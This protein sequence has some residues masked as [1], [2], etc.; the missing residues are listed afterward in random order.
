MLAKSPLTGLD[1][2][3]C[4]WAADVSWLVARYANELNINIETLIDNNVILISRYKCKESGFRFY[5]PSNIVGDS[6]FY[7]SL[8]QFDWYYMRSKWE[9]EEAITHINGQAVLE[10]GSGRGDFLS[11]AQRAHPDAELVGLELNQEA[12]NEA[13]RRGLN[14]LLETSTVHAGYRQKHY[15]AIACFQV[16][17]HVPEPMAFLMD[18]ITMLKRGGKLIV[19]VP[20]NSLR[21]TASIFVT[22]DQILNMP[23]HHQGLWDIPSLA[24]LQKVLP[25]RLE[26]LVVEPADA[27]HHR[28][29][30]RG[31]IKND[32]IQRLGR[33]VGLAVY[34]LGRPFYNHM[35]GYLGP[36]L[37]AHSI[38]A[39]YR[40]TGI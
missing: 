6:A 13:R 18:A 10:I 24:F 34:A 36:Y 3:E 23:P 8:S 21:A 40:R 25:L 38:L 19:G 32:L 2:V 4:E 22:P 7:E 26:S 28:Y 33:L 20:D 11:L 35:L 14:V 31:L 29:G 9:F 27:R 1:S 30:Y 12:A 37:P 17:E 39:V 15:D 5:Y 16:L